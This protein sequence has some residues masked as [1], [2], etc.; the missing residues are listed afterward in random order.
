MKINCERHYLWGAVDHER[1]A[2]ESFVTKTRDKRATLKF[3]KKTMK[4]YGRPAAIVILTATFSF[5]A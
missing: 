5:V 2:L 4:R 1:E 3:L